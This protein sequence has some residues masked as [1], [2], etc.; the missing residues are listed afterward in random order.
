L[1]I[2]GSIVLAAL[3]LDFLVLGLSSI[4]ETGRNFQDISRVIIDHSDS[5]FFGEAEFFA[6]VFGHAVFNI[7]I[8]L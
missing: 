5:Q 6:Q 8:V 2:K 1:D 4:R 3:F 7:L